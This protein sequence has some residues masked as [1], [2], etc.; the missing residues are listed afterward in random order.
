MT[1]VPAV[2]LC[3]LWPATVSGAEKTVIELWS[4]VSVPSVPKLQAFKAD[5]KT[6]A[7]LILDIEERTTNITRRPRAVE[8]VPAIENLLARAR[9]K[10]M[11]VVYSTTPK[12]DPGEILPQIAPRK[13]E[14]VVRSSVDKFF[15]TNLD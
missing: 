9:E 3:I 13:D 4:E 11:P 2:F 15:M 8:T 14:P 1:F 7:L 6:T 5:P 10:G 12:A